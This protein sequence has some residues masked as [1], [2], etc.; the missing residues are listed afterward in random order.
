MGYHWWSARYAGPI[1][2]DVS[3]HAALELKLPRSWR[4]PWRRHLLDDWS[5][6]LRGPYRSIY[7]EKKLFNRFYRLFLAKRADDKFA[8][9]V[10]FVYFPK[11]AFVPSTLTS[12][13][14]HGEDV[15]TLKSPPL[16]VRNLPMPEV[17][18][19]G[20]WK[21]RDSATKTTG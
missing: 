20:T 6:H 4:R 17:V 11:F 16:F 19:S 7:L 21:E 15:D 5:I 12:I 9:L 3:A 18:D 14:R 10:F 13:K 8:R 1:A 2:R